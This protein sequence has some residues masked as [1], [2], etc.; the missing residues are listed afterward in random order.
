MKFFP[1][2]QS[3]IAAEMAYRSAR[4]AFATLFAWSPFS[5]KWFCCL[6]P[7]LDSL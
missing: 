6:H 5:A 1:G 7:S 4:M 2:C 3:V